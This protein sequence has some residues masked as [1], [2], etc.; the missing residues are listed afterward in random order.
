MGLFSSVDLPGWHLAQESW[1]GMPGT[2]LG[3]DY[4]FHLDPGQRST[5]TLYQRNK[6]WLNAENGKASAEVWVSRTAGLC[7]VLAVLLC[8]K[9]WGV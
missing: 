4:S 9:L 7:P 1:K 2:F 3:E 6:N 8:K 5:G